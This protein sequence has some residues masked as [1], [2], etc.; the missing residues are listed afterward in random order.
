MLPPRKS[1]CIARPCIT[2]AQTAQDWGAYKR[3]AGLLSGGE[4]SKCTRLND[5]SDCSTAA[6]TSNGVSLCAKWL[7]SW[8]LDRAAL[9]SQNFVKWK[10][11]KKLS[12]AHSGDYLLEPSI[13]LETELLLRC[14]ASCLHRDVLD[15]V[16]AGGDYLPDP[17]LFD[18]SSR[19][20][21][22]HVL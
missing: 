18:G 10:F 2:P 22:P 15:R 7:L 9:N 12:S 1:F 14:L 8:V 3:K 21:Q 4:D 13:G 5:S 6:Y 20:V 19:V 11:A 16:R 17:L